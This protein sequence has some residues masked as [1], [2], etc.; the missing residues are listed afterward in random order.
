VFQAIQAAIINDQEKIGIRGQGMMADA[1]QQE[2]AEW[3][4]LSKK[5][6]RL[7]PTNRMFFARPSNEMGSL[8]K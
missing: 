5:K 2:H 6:H 3:S 1:D 4:I 7:K 8:I